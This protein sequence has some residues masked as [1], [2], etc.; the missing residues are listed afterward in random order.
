MQPGPARAA[1]ALP[2]VEA[3]APYTTARL[4]DEVRVGGFAHGVGNPERGTWD[5]NVEALTRRFDLFPTTDPFWKALAPRFHLGAS[6]STGGRTSQGYFG[7]TWTYDVTQR[8][9]VEGSFGG[10]VNDGR[11]GYDSV[12]PFNRAKLGCHVLFRESASIGYRLTESW[13]IMATVD[14][15]SNG[16]LCGLNRGLNNVGVRL[17]YSF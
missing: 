16:T 17:G 6:I 15:I 7:L 2:P 8:L 3:P 9:F 12:T 13:S 1:D 11:T 4:F 5:V 10:S 14:H